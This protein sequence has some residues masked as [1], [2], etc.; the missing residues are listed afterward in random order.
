MKK[1]KISLNEEIGGFAIIEAENIDKAEI[2]AERIIAQEGLAGY[3]DMEVVFRSAEVLSV[4][5]VQE[6]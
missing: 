5:E 4:E 3:K 2:E 1:F 6:R